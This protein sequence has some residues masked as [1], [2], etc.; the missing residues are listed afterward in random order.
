M[1]AMQ[2]MRIAKWSNTMSNLLTSADEN[3]LLEKV[4]QTERGA[5]DWTGPLSNADT[6]T[7]NDQS[8]QMIDVLLGHLGSQEF[9][10]IEMY[11]GLSGSEPLSA[12]AIGDRME[13]SGDAVLAIVNRTLR[14]LRMAELGEERERKVA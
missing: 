2:K 5:A 10:I 12:D 13:L 14:Q 11:F 4:A 3:A 1:E 9:E 6:L 8:K 7:K